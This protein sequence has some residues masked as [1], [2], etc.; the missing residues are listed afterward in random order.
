MTGKIIFKECRW[1]MYIMVLEYL[2]L[3]EI[4]ITRKSER[5]IECLKAKTYVLNC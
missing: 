2:L 3:H 1:Y 5:S 4:Y